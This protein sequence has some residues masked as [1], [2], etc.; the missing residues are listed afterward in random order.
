MSPPVLPLERL[1]EE[2]LTAVAHA[3]S[4]L[5]VDRREEILADLREHIAVA[6]AELSAP[7]EVAVRTI[8][9]RLGEP[10]DIA[11][12]ARLDA[13]PPSWHRP[14]PTSMA[15]VRPGPRIRAWVVALAV[16]GGVLVTVMVLVLGFV[17]VAH[18][19]DTGRP[20]APGPTVPHSR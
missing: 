18:Q 7:S 15:P 8:L 9:Q 4:D 11:A 12:E 10:G 19:G 3:C 5:P 17:L 2:Y 13:P 16:L 1:V 14:H 20:P 6:R